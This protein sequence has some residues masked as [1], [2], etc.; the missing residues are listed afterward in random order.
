MKQFLAVL[1]VFWVQMAIIFGLPSLY[2]L[3]TGD[4]LR[5]AVSGPVFVVL[6]TLGVLLLRKTRRE[7]SRPTGNPAVE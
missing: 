7:W 6:L 5:L 2:F 3:R 1:W 4:Y